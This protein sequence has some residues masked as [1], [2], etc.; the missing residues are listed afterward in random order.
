MPRKAAKKYDANA[1]VALHTH[2]GE[3]LVIRANPTDDEVKAFVAEHSR[4]YHTGEAGGPSGIPA[5]RIHKAE[6]YASELD[7]DNE[8]VAGEEIDLTDVLPKVEFP[9]T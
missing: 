7:V 6:R 2:V 1:V 4:R 9:T 8:E 3:T 5:Y